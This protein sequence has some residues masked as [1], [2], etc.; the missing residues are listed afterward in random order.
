[1]KQPSRKAIRTGCNVHFYRRNI[2]AMNVIWHSC[3]VE[4]YDCVPDANDAKYH[5][6]K[7][8]RILLC[9]ELA[10]KTSRDYMPLFKGNQEVR[11]L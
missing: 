8:G 3:F 1:M 2:H 4:A 9:D 6:E 10:N 11:A 5:Y 7:T